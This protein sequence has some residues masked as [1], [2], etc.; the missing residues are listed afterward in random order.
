MRARGAGGL[1][2]GNALAERCRNEHSARGGTCCLA[3]YEGL[4]SSAPISVKK[5]AFKPE[6]RIFSSSSVTGHAHMT[7]ASAR[8]GGAGGGGGGGGAG[9][10]G[11]AAWE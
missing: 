9:G 2:R 6:D 5:A 4:L 1:G 7:S 8:G 3:G 11:A 10:R